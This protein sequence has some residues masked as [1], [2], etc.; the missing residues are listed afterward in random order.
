MDWWS[1]PEEDKLMFQVKER[2]QSLHL[3]WT[4]N[5]AMKPL[6]GRL[7]KGAAIF[8]IDKASH[9][10]IEKG[11]DEYKLGR[12]VWTHY[13]GKINQTLWIVSAYCPNLY[14]ICSAKCIFSLHWQPE[15]SLKETIMAR[16]GMNGPFTFRRNNTKNPIDGIWTSP[17]ISIQ[18]GGYFAYDTLII[19]SDH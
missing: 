17:S 15:C 11:A 6:I 3:S 1:V 2:W 19:N 13:R 10:I 14:S 5:T 16:C 18:A 8:S 9:R 12:W 4:N 7:F